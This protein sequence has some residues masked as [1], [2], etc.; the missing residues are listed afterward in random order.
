MLV[1]RFVLTKSAMLL[2]EM[3]KIATWPRS[4]NSHTGWLAPALGSLEM[5]QCISQALSMQTRKALGQNNKV[6]AWVRCCLFTA[7][8]AIS[9][10]A[11]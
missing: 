4:A 8:L 9:S 11:H 10:F 3:V 7:P 2:E 5:L 6:C 1:R